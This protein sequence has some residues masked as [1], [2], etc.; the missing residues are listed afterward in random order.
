MVVRLR[1][2]RFVCGESGC[3]R[4]TFTEQVAGL[5]TP[6]SRYPPPL[7]AALTWIAVALAGRAGSRLAATLG[8]KAAR[9]TLLGLLRSTVSRPGFVGDFQPCEGRSHASTEEVPG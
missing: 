9:D 8:M 2:R 4:A 3:A 7:R 1:P 5:T 6:H